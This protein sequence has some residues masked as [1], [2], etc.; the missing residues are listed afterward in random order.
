VYRWQ[1]VSTEALVLRTVDYRDADR[2]VTLLTERLGKLSVIARSARRSRKRF[3]GALEPFAVIEAEIGSGR[4]ELKTLNQA[5]V[6]TAFP[7]ILKDLGKMSAAARALELVGGATPER[8]PEPALFRATVALFRMLDGGRE[9][10]EEALVSFQIR[11]TALLGFAPGLDACGKC[12][13]PA[14]KNRAGLFD[15]IA[16]H[17]VCRACGGAPLYLNASS[18]ARLQL[19][20]GEGWTEAVKKWPEK[21]LQQVRRAV[22]AFLQAHELS[23]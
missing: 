22:S 6:L 7:E 16:G 4:G 12:G 9:P 19:A 1:S 14:V 20:A 23:P 2:I 10:I 18:R 13:R 5:R 21:E 11:A 8:Q 3:V 17:L 15:P